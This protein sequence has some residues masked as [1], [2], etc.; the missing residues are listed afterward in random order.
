MMSE[1]AHPE[2]GSWA[3]A[4]GEEPLPPAVEAHLRGCAACTGELARLRAAAGL[5]G[6][7]SAHEPPAR[8]RGRIMATALAS[9]PTRER[10]V[11]PYARQ[12]TAL[13]ALLSEL[14][15]R[16]LALPEPHYGNVDGVLTHLTGNDNLVASDLGLIQPSR[17]MMV[18]SR[19]AWR[20]QAYGLLR[21]VGVSAPLDRP[22]RMAGRAGLRRPLRDAIVQR[23]FETWIHADDI[24]RAVD[25]PPAAPPPED[26]GLIVSLG[27]R[28]LPV[29]MRALGCEHPGRSAT[30]LLG[31]ASPMLWRV[32]LS[33]DAESGD[34]V[35]RVSADAV[36]FCELM[37][38]RRSL[39][40][41][42]YQTEG[43]AVAAHDL[44]RAA[45]TL[46]CD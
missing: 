15:V 1:N 7:A 33:M 24:R 13:Q 32:P 45:A 5:L 17:T 10:L 42:G 11:E 4:L 21:G 46:G 25:R 20:G 38:N 26:V 34:E 3:L 41:F 35:V 31:G 14:D 23:T 39:E 36:G 37:A 2:L 28:L 16:Q 19:E 29:A 9:R 30:V 8:L 43:D 40:G 27:L 18:G 44:L 22:V 6:A 12:V